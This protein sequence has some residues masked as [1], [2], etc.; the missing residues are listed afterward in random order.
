MYI[1]FF[2]KFFLYILMICISYCVIILLHANPCSSYNRKKY[3]K[4]LFVLTS[5]FG[6]M[7]A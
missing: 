4:W 2:L 5:L 1:L 3:K 7:F 6:T